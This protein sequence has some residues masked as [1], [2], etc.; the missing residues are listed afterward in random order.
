[1]KRENLAAGQQRSFINV[2]LEMERF[3][4]ECSSRVSKSTGTVKLQEIQWN[5]DLLIAL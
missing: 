3:L 2:V 5:R 1:M 4:L